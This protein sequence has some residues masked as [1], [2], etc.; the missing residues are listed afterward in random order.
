MTESKTLNPEDI[1][2]FSGS[3]NMTL[4]E[5]IAA[6]IGVPLGETKIKRFT[7]DNLYV[8][9]TLSKCPFAQCLYHPIAHAAGE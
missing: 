1:R 6:S 2:I 4:A 7:N 5:D 3:S 9:F 8:Q